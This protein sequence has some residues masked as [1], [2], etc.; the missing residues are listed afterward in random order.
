MVPR[1]VTL[2]QV[3]LK[4]QNYV[5]L[6]KPLY[7]ASSS[8]LS[9]IQTPLLDQVWHLSLAATGKQDKTFGMFSQEAMV[10]LWLAAA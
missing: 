8:L 3:L 1:G 4:F 2:N 10:K 5:A 6:A 9:L 7:V